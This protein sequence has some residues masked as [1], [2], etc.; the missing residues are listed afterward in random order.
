MNNALSNEIIGPLS[1]L[2]DQMIESQFSDRYGGF[3]SINDPIIEGDAVSII[4]MRI[5]EAIT[6]QWLAL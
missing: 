1:E 4:I 3:A 6:T 5:Q 2:F